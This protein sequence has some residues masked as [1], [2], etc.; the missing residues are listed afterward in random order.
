MNAARKQM[1]FAQACIAAAALLLGSLPAVL[2]AQAVSS[3]W[4]T[5]HHEVVK[6]TNAGQQDQRT[7]EVHR[8]IAAVV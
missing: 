8:S 2:R 1:K 7:H 6:R 5:L 3:E 4:Q